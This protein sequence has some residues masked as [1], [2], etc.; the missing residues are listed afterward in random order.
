MPSLKLSLRLRWL[1]SQME[2][3]LE[4]SDL[5]ATQLRTSHLSNLIALDSEG[6]RPHAPTLGKGSQPNQ[7]FAPKL[8]LKASNLELK[9]ANHGYLYV[10]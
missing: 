4:A 2:D 3:T 5:A 10:P 9:I 6:L 7:S 1:S 8:K